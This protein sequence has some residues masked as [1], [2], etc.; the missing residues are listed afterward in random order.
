M[1][2]EEILNYKL[3]VAAYCRVST[4]LEMQDCSYEIQEEYFK[5]RIRE[6]PHMELVGIYGDKGKSGVKKSSRSGLKKLMKDCEAGKIDLIMTKS[7]SR[8]ARN[9]AD[10]IELIQKLRSMN[11][12][13]WFEKE[14]LRTDD[15]RCDLLISI[16]AALAQEESN[17]ISQNMIR[18]HLQLA[19]EGRP[20]S[21]TSYGYVTKGP[22]R[23]QIIPHEA[24]MIR[25]AF[26][27]AAEGKK[28]SEILE[29]MNQREAECGSGYRWLQK[30][31][32][33][34]LRNVVYIGDF[35]SH[36]NVKISVS[37]GEIVNK[38][39][40]DRYYIKG[41]HPAIVSRELFDRVQSMMKSRAL[42]SFIQYPS[43]EQL[44]LLN[45]TS[46]VSPA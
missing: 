45:D 28:Y 9:M 16:M 17:S 27:M 22:D 31:L 19:A 37:G 29:A 24:E 11:V 36:A 25:M 21:H 39:Y 34:L 3:K 41:H 1:T 42:W 26:Q 14:G 44:V 13:V 2:T 30:R 7:I 33:H 4:K 8:F 23:W 38:G 43:P 10:C 12:V 40:R 5:I 35:Y 15:P 6:D 20:A 18:S 46:W 32:R